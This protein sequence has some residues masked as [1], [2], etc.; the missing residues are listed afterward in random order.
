VPSEIAAV[1]PLANQQ[2]VALISPSVSRDGLSSLGPYLFSDSMTNEMQGRAMAKYAVEKLGLKRFAIL[3]PDDSYGSTLSQ[4]FQKTVESMGATVMGSETYPTNSA[5]FRKQLLDLGGQDPQSSKENDRENNRRLEELKYAL[6]KEVGKILLKSKEVLANAAQDASDQTPALAF[7]PLV[8]ALTNTTTSSVVKSINDSL[9]DSFKE[10]TDFVL[11]NDDLVK[12]ALKRLPV[13]FQGTTLTVSAE[14]WGDV[15]QDLEAS[16]IVAGRIIENNPPGDWTDHPTW[17]F[18]LYLE[19]FQLNAKKT[20]FV[21]IYQNKLPYSTFKPSS[22]IRA[23]SGYQAL[24]LPAHSVEIPSLVSQIH[25][26]D[27][28]PVFL[29]GH[30]WDNDSVRQDGA[31][32]VEGSYYVTGFYL[33]SSQGN[34]KKFADDYLKKFAKKPDLLAAQ[35]YDAARLMLKATETSVSRDDIHNNLLA[36]KDFDGVSGKTTFG[37]HGEADKI[38]PVLKIQDGKVQQVQ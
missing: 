32:D 29:G 2:R 7:V 36:I 17:D 10:Q 23:V 13:E 34:T 38:V 6:K 37:G 35:A 31:K 28:N 4:A 14:Q 33:D 19:A 16:M 8:E 15:G 9:R 24:Y 22:L 26:Y 1:A 27:L 21:K 20:A 12:D 5:D 18:S 3:A 25:F 11:R 30:L